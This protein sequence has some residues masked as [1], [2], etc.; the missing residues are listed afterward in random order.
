M[1]IIY[2]RFT[3]KWW[4]SIYWQDSLKFCGCVVWKS[5]FHWTQM[6]LKSLNLSL[7]TNIIQKNIHYEP[8]AP[9]YK[10]DWTPDLVKNFNRLHIAWS[11]CLVQAL[12][13]P[14]LWPSVSTIEVSTIFYITYMVRV[15]SINFVLTCFFKC[16]CFWMQLHV[17]S[18][19][20]R[21]LL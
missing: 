9:S 17:W 15:A 18:I 11:Y 7:H 10:S 1:Y 19:S 16:F 5:L 8:K 14:P 6:W 12:V 20:V 21:I 2:H 13:Y 3:M 4:Q